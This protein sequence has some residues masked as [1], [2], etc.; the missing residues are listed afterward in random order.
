MQTEQYLDGCVRA[1]VFCF[2]V[3]VVVVVMEK[4]MNKRERGLM[5]AVKCGANINKTKTYIQRI[6]K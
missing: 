5:V 2:V 3:V 4:R 1:C 6:Q